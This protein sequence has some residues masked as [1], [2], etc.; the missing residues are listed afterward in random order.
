MR[1]AHGP[2][3]S[4]SLRPRLATIP[5]PYRCD[6]DYDHACYS[7]DLSYSHNRRLPAD[8]GVL[9]LCIHRAVPHEESRVGWPICPASVTLGPGADCRERSWRQKDPP[10]C[11]GQGAWGQVTCVACLVAAG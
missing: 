1:G 11:S 7:S 8:R 6:N 3:C 2:H 4:T 5:S 10:P 9:A